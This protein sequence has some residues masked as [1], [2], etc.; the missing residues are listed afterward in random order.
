MLFRLMR[1][2]DVEHKDL[3]VGTD[4]VNL[5]SLYLLLSRP[6]RNQSDSGL[7]CS[8]SRSRLGLLW[9]HVSPLHSDV[10]F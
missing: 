1:K 3:N 6:N 4:L 5:V 7:T 8:D 2:P 9:K 10:L